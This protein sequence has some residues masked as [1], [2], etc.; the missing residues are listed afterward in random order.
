MALILARGGSKGIP[1]KNLAKVG[2]ISLLERALN[3]VKNSKVF[4]DV[5]V[6]TDSRLIAHHLNFHR[7]NVHMRHESAARDEST[8]LEAVIEFLN[9][10]RHVHNIALVQ[11]TSVFIREKYLE[12]AVAHF[13][14]PSVDCVFAATRSRNQKSVNLECHCIVFICRSWKLRW[15]QVNSNELRPI[16]FDT[17][18]RPRRQDWDGELLETGMFYFARRR[19]IETHGLLQ[20]ER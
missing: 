12:L 10:H 14:N 16:N 3:V 19:L 6:S 1:L 9:G 4:D 20:N 13:R 15:Q 18:D 5:W 11:C 8:S 17:R 7:A 2:A